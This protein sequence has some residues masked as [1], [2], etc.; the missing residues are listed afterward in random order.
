[1]KP[2][3]RPMYFISL[4]HFMSFVSFVPLIPTL[5]VTKI[6]GFLIFS[7]SIYRYQWHEWVMKYFTIKF[8]SILDSDFCHQLPCHI[9]YHLYH[10]KN[11]IK[12]LKD[13]K[14]E[15]LCKK[16]IWL[17]KELFE[18]LSLTV[19]TKHLDIFTL[20]QSLIRGIFRALL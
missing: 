9:K 3:W 6:S 20:Y 12:L 5:K 11:Q 18:S 1:M 2:C 8:K 7:D 17:Q 15:T 10:I 4:T 13:F 14:R 19:L 16:C